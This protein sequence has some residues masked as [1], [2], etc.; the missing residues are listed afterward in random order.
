MIIDCIIVDDEPI[1]RKGLQGYIEKISF[2]KLLNA[3]PD[4]LSAME[5]IKA[6]PHAILLLD[7]NMPHLSGM[8]LLRTLT[9]KPMTIIISAYA[10][11]ALES[12]ELDVLDY[13]VK[14]VAFDRFLKA[15]N[16]A[17]DYISLQGNEKNNAGH[18][19]VKAD[20]R[21]E[22]IQ[23]DEVLYIE[24]LQNYVAI[25]TQHKKFIS[26]ISLKSLEDFL[27][28]DQFV[29]VHKSFMV[30]THKVQSIEGDELLIGDK[31]IPVSRANREEIVQTILGNRFLKRGM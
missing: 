27:P 16:K 9:P 2:L 8:E 12:Y 7:I 15:V 31:R 17:K 14:P 24:S 6:H 4:A 26:L 3:F 20:N 5:T 22:R 30:N 1:A 18:F 10:E 13:I 28:K 23:M 19:F 21:I 29:K 25:H 11:H